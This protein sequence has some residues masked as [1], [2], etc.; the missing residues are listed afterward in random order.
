MMMYIEWKTVWE[1]ANK[2]DD[3]RNPIKYMCYP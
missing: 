2:Y 3:E 1:V